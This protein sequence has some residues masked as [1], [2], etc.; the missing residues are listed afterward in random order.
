MKRA[1]GILSVLVLMMPLGGSAQGTN[2]VRSGSSARIVIEQAADAPTIIEVR[3][4]PERTGNQELFMWMMPR[5]VGRQ[6]AER[7]VVPPTEPGLYRL[8]HTFRTPGEWQLTFRHGV[9]LD[10]YYTGVQLYIDPQ[11]SPPVVFDRNFRP[12]LAESAPAY[13][14]PMGFGILAVITAL[15]VTLIVV[16]LRRLR[17]RLAINP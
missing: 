15:T 4:E 9:G 16:T 7:R 1:V 12:D 3:T 10:V 17:R 2:A 11:G 8:E 14:Q 6:A 5:G 13:L